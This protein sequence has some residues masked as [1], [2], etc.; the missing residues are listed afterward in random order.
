MK[1]RLYLLLPLILCFFVTISCCF[2]SQAQ[3]QLSKSSPKDLLNMILQK[4]G[5]YSNYNVETVSGKFGSSGS[6]GYFFVF[7]EKSTKKDDSLNYCVD[8]WYGSSSKV[9]KVAGEQYI[10][11]D[12]FGSI[13]LCGK[14]YF[15]YDLS[16]ATDSQTILLGVSGS[17]CIESFR[18]P[19]SAK[20]GESNS[21]T[22]MCS[23]YDL[24]KLKDDD[25][26]AGHTWKNYYF[27]VDSKGFHEYPAKQISSKDFNKYANAA[28][29]LK[30][31]NTELSKKNTKV[32]YSFLKRSNNLIHINIDIDT[33]ESV[34]YSYRTYQI[35]KNNKLTLVDSGDGSYMKAVSKLK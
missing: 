18:A 23:A 17:K 7:T 33:S 28:T 16:Y 8:I 9:S 20:F 5:T 34:S 30:N 25:F 11:P 13:K 3:V 32:S 4:D 10:L 6:L 27:Y 15:R 1:K 31:L 29:I 22:V 26:L 2:S 12:T 35:G 14:T 24:I 21:F 19:G